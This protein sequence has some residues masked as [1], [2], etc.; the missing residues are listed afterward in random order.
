MKVHPRPT[1]YEIAR[2]LAGMKRFI[3]CVLS[4]LLLVPT[5][6]QAYSGTSTSAAEVILF[7]LL[8]LTPLV[9]PPALVIWAYRRPHNRSVQLLQGLALVFHCWLWSYLKSS[10]E[11]RHWGGEWLLLYFDALL[12]IALLLNGLVQARLAARASLRLLW[13]GAAVVGGEQLVWLVLRVAGSWQWQLFGA[14]NQLLYQLWSLFLN[15]LV[16]LLSWT[17]VVRHLRRQPE[18]SVALWQQPW[19]QAPVLAG[20]I[21][22]GVALLNELSYTL[23]SP[24]LSTNWASM[25]WGL[26]VTFLFTS[27]M[28][29]L[30]LRLVSPLTSELELADD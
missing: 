19:W 25:M 22:A 28:G 21:A 29:V 13:V 17:L 1:G 26:C 11:L 24:H 9:L 2:Y 18:V 15:G 16:A 23:F 30:A 8:L 27:A 5:L 6:A 7:L 20:S 10:N 12:P 14:G 3:L 4:G